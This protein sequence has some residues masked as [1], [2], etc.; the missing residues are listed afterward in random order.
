MEPSIRSRL[1]AAS[2]R[3]A[4]GERVDFR[5]WRME[6]VS[7]VVDELSITG[8][9]GDFDTSGEPVIRKANASIGVKLSL[10]SGAIQYLRSR[11]APP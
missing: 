9:I 4:R 11:R 10:P 6:L 1:R 7:V 3:T 5:R 8:L 2:A